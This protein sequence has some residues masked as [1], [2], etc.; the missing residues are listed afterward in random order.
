MD[1]TLLKGLHVL[2]FLARNPGEHTLAELVDQLGLLKSN[3]H[4]T[5]ATLIEAGFVRPGSARGTYCASLKLWDLGNSVSAQ[6]DIRSLAR[7]AMQDLSARTGESII[8]GVKEGDEVVYIERCLPVRPLASNLRVGDRTPVHTTAMGKV[9]LA[10]GPA[11][12]LERLPARL[13]RHSAATV[14][15]R[16]RLAQELA[17]VRERGH[18]VSRGELVQEIGGIAAPVFGRDGTVCAALSISSPLSRQTAKEKAYVDLVVGSA[19]RISQSI[20]AA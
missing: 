5:L 11:A 19:R 20:A 7:P 14:T 4:R 2:E 10:F 9:L 6:L 17:D 12:E 16:A 18:A 3:V 13:P 15:S 8:L 1:K